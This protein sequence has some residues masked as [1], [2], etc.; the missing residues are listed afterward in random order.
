TTL[1]AVAALLVLGGET[2]KV[3]SMTLLVGIVVGTY[4]SICVASPLWVSWT[5]WV[6]HR[7]GRARQVRS[8]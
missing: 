1:F 6:H 4:S 3:F 7:A 2:L 5:E 8:S